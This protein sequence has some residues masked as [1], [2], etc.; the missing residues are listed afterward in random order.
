MK[1]IFLDIDGVLNS[2]K[3]FIENHIPNLIYH[4]VYDYN[5]IENK[6]KLQ[7]LEL[8]F[9]KIELLKKIVFETNCKIVISSC[10]KNLSTYPLVE[11][12][13]VQKGLPII[14]ATPVAN[15]RGEEI[16]TYLKEHQDI[17]GF[18]ILDDEIFDD[19]DELENFLVKTSFY[20]DG[21]TEEHAEE[22]IYLLN[23]VKT[24]KKTKVKE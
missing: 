10:W 7:V 12:Y 6:Q 14:G 9:Y 15:D 13:L 20:E 16:R 4:Q 21:L 3:Y 24:R 2:Q 1:V 17:D 11:E 18:I 5:I 22:A 19:F 23:N 8:D